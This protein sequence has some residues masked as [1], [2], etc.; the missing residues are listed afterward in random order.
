MK[1][2]LR[3]QGVENKRNIRDFYHANPFTTQS[4]CAMALG[5]HKDT[6][7]RHYQKFRKAWKD[8]RNEK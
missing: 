1:K 7:A 3:E 4:E 2:T 6:V 8:E 5:V